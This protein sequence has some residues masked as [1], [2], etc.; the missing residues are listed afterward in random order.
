MSDK[1]DIR[2]DQLCL[3]RVTDPYSANFVETI[4]VFRGF[5]Q[6]TNQPRDYRDCPVSG[7]THRAHVIARVRPRKAN[8]VIAQLHGRPLS[9]V[10]L[11]YALAV[12]FESR[13]RLSSPLF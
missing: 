7:H 4:R 12:S 9:S 13:Y 11:A 2:I 5:D 6:T 1:A 3:A 8:K 10:S